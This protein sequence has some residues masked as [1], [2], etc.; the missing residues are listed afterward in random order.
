MRGAEAKVA[1]SS[2]VFSEKERR[3]AGHQRSVGASKVG[4]CL[5]SDEDDAL[6]NCVK[7]RGRSWS[8]RLRRRSLLESS[9]SSSLS[10]SLVVAVE[11]ADRCEL[12][13]WRRWKV[14]GWKGGGLWMKQVG[15]WMRGAW[16]CE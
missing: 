10:L 7:L 9:S 16:G 15:F 13:G 4:T 5:L 3:G 6:S 12:D 2:T 14:C 11:V 1:N 8:K